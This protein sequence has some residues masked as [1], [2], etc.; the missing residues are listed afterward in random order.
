MIII[1]VLSYVVLYYEFGKIFYLVNYYTNL[2]GFTRVRTTLARTSF[3]GAEFVNKTRN[4]HFYITII[5]ILK[6]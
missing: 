5:I 1:I 3:M 2:K 6:F 4:I